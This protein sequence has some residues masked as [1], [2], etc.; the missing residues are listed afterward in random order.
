VLD[1]EPEKDLRMSLTPLSPS[2]VR[3]LREDRL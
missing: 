1:T 2:A 3:I